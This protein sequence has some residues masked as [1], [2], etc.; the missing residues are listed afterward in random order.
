ME[1]QKK[2]LAMLTVILIA[3]VIILIV[4][5]KYFDKASEDVSEENHFTINNI[6]ADKVIRFA[7]TNSAGTVSLTKNAQE[8]I[9]DNDSSLDMDEDKVT[10]LIQT[11]APLN[12][13]NRIEEVE[14][15][16]MYGLAEPALTILVSDGE[17]VCTMMIG[18]LNEMTGTYYLCLEGKESVIYDVNPQIVSAFGTTLEDLVTAKE[19]TTEAQSTEEPTEG[20]E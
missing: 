2:Q 9:Y 20:V 4:L 12:S 16:E 17:E 7:F 15:L 3:A 11:V 8:W 5:L 14:N 6:Q 18:D 1:R 13:E 19:Q 10:E